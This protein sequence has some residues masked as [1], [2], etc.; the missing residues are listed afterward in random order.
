M[1]DLDKDIL[2]IIEKWQSEAEF[3]KF[4]N[5]QNEIK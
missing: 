3:S 4:E 1:Q 5:F 2:S